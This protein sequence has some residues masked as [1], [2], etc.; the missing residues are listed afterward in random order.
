MLTLSSKFK[1]PQRSTGRTQDRTAK[2]SAGSAP[3]TPFA[4]LVLNSAKVPFRY[5][6]PTSPLSAPKTLEATPKTTTTS[7]QPKFNGH[8]DTHL[9]QNGTLP[10]SP[11]EA[12]VTP[13][14]SRSAAVIIPRVLTTAERAQ[15]HTAS[16][17]PT[18]T[19]KVNGHLLPSAD[20]P[21]G[22]NFDQ[23][24]KADTS[25]AKFQDL[26]LTVFEAE[27]DLHQD[28]VLRSHKT[29]P[30]LFAS[31]ETPEGMVTVLQPA[32]LTQLDS[33]LI[34]VIK[35]GGLQRIQV[36]S[37]ARIQKFCEQTIRAASTVS[38]GIVD[39]WDEQDVREWSDRVVL[40]EQGLSA[41]KIV[42]RIMTAG[43]EEKQLFSEETLRILVD[44]LTQT[45]ESCVITNVE[46]RPN[47]DDSSVYNIAHKNSKVILPVFQACAR[48][49]LLLGNL[50]LKTD[51]DETVVTS[52]ESL[53]RN[54]I[55]VE[56]ASSE[57]EAVLGIQN[58]ET[59]RKAAMDVLAKIFARY[60]KDR[61]SIIDSILTSL[62]RLPVTRQSARQYKLTDAK[63]IQLVS[64]L[65]MR[66]I[67]ATATRSETTS[68]DLIMDKPSDA[69][70]NSDPSE[71]ECDSSE[72]K[73][74]KRRNAPKSRAA[75]LN[76]DSLE[77]YLKFL[78]DPASAN[79]TYV[80]D[81]LLRRA[82]TS[83]KSSDEPYRN[84]LDIFVEDFLNVLGHADWPAAELMLRQLVSRL[85]DLTKNPKS[86]APSKAMS[87]ELMGHM[88][89]AIIDLQ[90]KAQKTIQSAAHEPSSLFDALR[91]FGEAVFSDDVD[92]DDLISIDGPFRM[93]VEYLH[94]RPHTDAQAF[95][96]CG[97]HLAQ[98]A[99]LL[100]PP[101]VDPA[102]PSLAPPPLPSQANMKLQK[103]LAQMI[104]DP[105]KLQVDDDFPQ[106][107]ATEGCL[108]AVLVTLR[109]PFCRLFNVIFNHLLQAMS[110]DQASI[111]SKSLKSVDQVL[112]KDPSVLDRGNFVMRGIIQCLADSSPQVRDSALGLL[113]KCLLLRPKMDSHVLEA[114]VNRT[115]DNATGVKKR[116]LKMLKDIYLR[117][118]NLTMRTRIAEA[119][120]HRISD[121][122]ETVV[123]L[124]RQILEEIWFTP[125]YGMSRSGSDAL[126]L[127]L[128]LRQLAALLIAL[129]QQ[130]EAVFQVLQN[131]LVEVMSPKSKAAAANVKVCKDIVLALVDAIIDDTDLPNKPGRSATMETLAIFAQANPKLFTFTQIQPLL[132]YL[133][134]LSDVDDLKVYRNTVIIIRSTLPHIPNFSS[135]TIVETQS[136]LMKSVAK[137]HKTELKEVAACLWKLTGMLNN[138]DK[139]VAVTRSSLDR[140]NKQVKDD[141]ATDSVAAKQVSRLL[142]IAGNFVNAFDLDAHLD[143]FKQTFPNFKG[144]SVAN[145][146]IDII[147]PLTSPKQSLAMREIALEN[148]C[149]MCEAWPTQYQ[150][151]DVCRAIELVFASKE[152]TLELVL[153][154]AF[155]DFFRPVEKRKDEKEKPQVKGVE[156]GAERIGN[157]YV[158]TDR[159]GASTSIAQRFLPEVI[160][161][162]L[163]SEGDVALIS[164]QVVASINRSGLVHPKESAPCLVALETSPI[165]QIASIAF[166]EH[167]T[168]FSK[169]ESMYE[170]ENMRAIVQAFSYQHD[171]VKNTLG[172]T[173][174]PP[175]AKLHYFWEVMK[176]S[177]AKTRK[178]F[179][180]N[181][182]TR[183]DFEPTKIDT[184][185]DAPHQMDFSR[186]CAENLAFFDYTRLDDVMQLVASLEKVVTST[187][188]G[189]AHGI[190][191]LTANN[192]TTGNAMP[193]ANGAADVQMEDTTTVQVLEVAQGLAEAMVPVDTEKLRKLA[194]SSQALLLLWDTRTYLRRLYNLSKPNAAPK[195]RPPKDKEKAKD[196]TRAPTRIPN[197]VQIT[198]RYLARNAEI[199]KALATTDTQRTICFQ[200]QQLMSIDDEV[201]VANA[202]DADAEVDLSL[203]DEGYGTPSEDSSS[204][205]GSKPPGTPD[206]RGRKRKSTPGAGTA[207]STPKKRRA[208]SKG[209]AGGKRK[210][211]GKRDENEDWD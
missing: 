200:F 47:G 188:A 68:Q 7:V 142:A 13:L 106:T 112:E 9:A 118:D 131:L 58:F 10:P 30:D 84:L 42:L 190:E 164:A 70:S 173:G 170:K 18:D 29:T 182:C 93:V 126:Q 91:A 161:I 189:V 207:G 192:G 202:D 87:L 32:I 146:A 204:R 130:S 92:D 72:E 122:E 83:S 199:A 65:L 1:P 17:E 176:V 77:S 138:F 175:V 49:L 54:L 205:S 81:F 163:N 125:L 14:P 177:S 169:H 38:I 21:S 16:E 197:S 95:T 195:G 198:E 97:Y 73:T 23:R 143:M 94:Q 210:S 2:G 86:S 71:S 51:V 25:V 66:L 208:S 153:V 158:A 11:S 156:A 48:L 152:P 160:R 35:L 191:D 167:R 117:N 57:R 24:H 114:V 162:A 141:F 89:S 178:K 85:Y 139:L 134:N 124:A 105:E 103:Q 43:R 80:V 55:F 69:D 46:S 196:L 61:Q 19:I 15:Y 20:A 101:P 184:S 119:L 39:G 62:E 96:A 33:A 129:V 82:L 50:L 127:K 151:A 123:E 100:L 31:V 149:L 52:A 63:P 183:L 144:K 28:P 108:A 171:I 111:R 157:T 12:L 22:P 76:S 6:T 128:N 133:R 41:S 5:P 136:V 110:A 67:Q 115:I 121:V 102:R 179:L 36:D 40:A 211:G 4:Q 147:C 145:L 44:M 109:L 201:K 3:L 88:L 155:D 107:S 168:L 113:A 59:V 79:A 64:A 186:F 120:V 26:I 90:H 27:L 98:W 116:S 172:Y 148:I 132:P 135:T 99:Y 154:K 194:V 185:G 181:I 78:W 203:V 140:I 75:A 150:R 166:E 45:I 159:D 53:C 180:A 8:I 104:K 56:N 74:Q 165:A 37:I 137:L 174:I 34:K 193:M 209:A 60:T 187:G 206:K